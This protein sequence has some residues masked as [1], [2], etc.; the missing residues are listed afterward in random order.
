[1]IYIHVPFCKSKCIYC[2]FY[3]TV[4]NPVL[5]TRYVR[6]LCQ[7]LKNRRDYLPNCEIHS[8]YFGGG[9][10][11]MLNLVEIETVMKCIRQQY[12]VN[13]KAEITFEANPDDITPELVRA[14]IEL[15][16]NRVSLGVQTFDDKLLRMLNRR[17]TSQ[18][19]CE[20]VYTLVH[21]GIT[22]VSIDLIYG[23]PHQ[24]LEGFQTDLTRAFTLPITHLS[25]YALSV[26][27]NT[28]LFQKIKRGELQLP[29]EDLFLKEYTALMNEAEAHKFEHYEI[30]NFA[31]PGY[32]SR[33]NSGYWLGTPY[34]GCGPG[35]HSFD[36]KNRWYNLPNLFKYVQMSSIPPHEVEILNCEERFN[37]FIMVSLRTRRG[38]N[39][40]KIEDR[41][42]TVFL[43]HTIQIAASAIKKGLLENCNGFLK[44]TRNGIFVSDDIMSDFMM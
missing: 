6:A 18:K 27:E 8:I 29:D 43:R 44:L 35:A 31:L 41:F 38:I 37:E 7:E 42:G 1:M 25:S 15:G 21:E 28:V 14:L 16:F 30:S 5:Q 36:G 26:E 23:L 33:H 10:P 34:L 22:N 24:T 12:K 32:E 40:Q 17:H 4:Q 13:L 19:A 3:S 11:S 20:A 9:T 39:L 2:D